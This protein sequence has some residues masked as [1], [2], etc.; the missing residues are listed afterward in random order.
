MAIYMGKTVLNEKHKTCQIGVQFLD[1]IH[2]I[3]SQFCSGCN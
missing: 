1:A 3:G 2:A